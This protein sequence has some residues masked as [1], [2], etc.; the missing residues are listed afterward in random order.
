MTLEK[1]SVRVYVK[2]RVASF[3]HD[4]VL[5]PVRHSPIVEPRE[6]LHDMER[7]EMVKKSVY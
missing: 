2:R 7:S 4:R 5:C 3:P 6:G 1:K